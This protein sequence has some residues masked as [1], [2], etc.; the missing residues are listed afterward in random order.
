MTNFF[1]ADGNKSSVGVG[2]TS[3]STLTDM[4]HV[5]GSLRIENS[6]NVVAGQTTEVAP[7]NDNTAKRITLRRQATLPGNGV[8]YIEV[9]GWTGGAS[10]KL[11]LVFEE[12]T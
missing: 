6:L 2:F 3:T 11:Y 10:E 8:G 12:A 5:N 4:L 9:Q 1:I 7:L